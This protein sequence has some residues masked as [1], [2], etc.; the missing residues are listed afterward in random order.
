ML[1]V[2]FK[3]FGIIGLLIGLLFSLGLIS[4]GSYFLYQTLLGNDVN[5]GDIG[6]GLFMITE[7]GT[8]PNPVALIINL[9]FLWLGLFLL[10]S[11][12]ED[13][14][15]DYF[16]YQFKEKKESFILIK[17]KT[18]LKYM[19]WYIVMVALYAFVTL[20]AFGFIL[21]GPIT[22]I[23]WLFGTNLL[24]HTKFFYENYVFTGSTAF[25]YLKFWLLGLPL[26]Y[27]FNIKERGWKIGSPSSWSR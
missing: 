17:I 5:T 18:I 10:K 12:G 6:P 26:T 22:F 25:M 23:D 19:T 15:R 14:L 24:S 7:L 2:I 11:G 3:I 1:E 20:L 21:W 9:S 27:L 4:T 16:N 13:F 8:L